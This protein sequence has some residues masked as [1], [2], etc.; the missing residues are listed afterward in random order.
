[1]SALLVDLCGASALRELGD[2]LGDAAD[3][4]LPGA[5][6]VIDGIIGGI[7]DIGDAIGGL[8]GGTP[9]ALAVGLDQTTI[10]EAL[11]LPRSPMADVGWRIG[12]GAL[13]GGAGGEQHLV[14]AQALRAAWS[15]HWREPLSHAHLAIIIAHERSR[16]G[17]RAALR[18][19]LGQR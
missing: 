3:C 6:G 19:Q 2:V 4:I 12:L 16:P 8:I 14:R 9:S 17:A 1:M 15:G 7:G 10:V 18:E 5:G 11:Q 13:N